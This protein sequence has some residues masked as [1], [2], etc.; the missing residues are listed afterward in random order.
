MTKASPDYARLDPAY[1]EGRRAFLR[2]PC[3]SNAQIE[4]LCPHKRISGQFNEKRSA[5]WTGWYEARIAGKLGHILE[6]HGMT[7]P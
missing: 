4:K 7:Y 3:L 6:R 2:S 1:Q 5:W